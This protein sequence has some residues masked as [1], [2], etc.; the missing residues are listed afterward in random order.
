MVQ[1]LRV[2]SL[3][4]LLCAGLAI[5]QGQLGPAPG[6]QL[7][8]PAAKLDEIVAKLAALDLGEP[9]KAEFALGYLKQ[10]G[11]E[12]EGPALAAVGRFLKSETPR[13]R[14]AAARLVMDTPPAELVGDLKGAAA[15]L[16]PDEQS[17][18]AVNLS[19][20]H[21]DGEL[22]D[23][24]VARISDPEI[25]IDER[26]ALGS[27]L[28]PLAPKQL[29]L[30]YAE[31]LKSPEEPIRYVAWKRLTQLAGTE[32]G[33]TYQVWR[34]WAEEQIELS[35][36]LPKLPAEENA[37]FEPGDGGIGVHIREAGHS[38]KVWGVGPGSPAG[39]V[40]LEPG[41]L[42]DAV[43]GMPVAIR[44]MEEMVNFEFRGEPGTPVMITYRKPGQPIKTV[45]L[46]RA[47]LKVAMNQG[48]LV[49][50]GA[51]VEAPVVAFPDEVNEATIQAYI[52]EIL[53]GGSGGFALD[54]QRMLMLRRV[55]PA[56]VGLLLEAMET[57]DLRPSIANVIETIAD[58]SHREMIV[59]RLT[60]YPELIDCVHDHGWAPEARQQLL[61][62]LAKELEKDDPALPTDWINAI[63]QLQDPKS[64]PMLVDYFRRGRYP[65][66]TYDAI[67][68]IPGID[69][70]DAIA[71]MWENA[72]WRRELAGDTDVWFNSSYFSVR[73]AAQI[74]LEWGHVEALEVCIS[75]MGRR[76][77]TSR[78]TW[79]DLVR[80]H[81]DFVGTP[82]Q[83]EGWFLANRGKLIFVPATKKYVVAE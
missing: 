22:L 57:E 21:N 20:T 6:Q 15:D 29:V 43:N 30:A 28:L 47:E 27:Q 78:G 35:G 67:R 62:G 65:A 2:L 24:L 72:S 74:A 23:R 19:H 80:Q 61:D 79:D 70:R 38:L 45:E 77:W 83:T 40:G 44:S 31:L 11:A 58:E 51:F 16:D 7:L 68:G 60:D 17:T 75:R 54:G 46:K 56:Y 34:G 59:A 50:F 4:T 3:Q 1:I 39:E 82:E 37:N 64:F 42:I 52:D 69:L 5:G 8:K 10:M 73:D 53:T 25:E 14:A 48:G 32:M 9:D 36:D 63:V 66:V 81:I 33:K 12:L 76:E 49:R 13:V 41:D 18:L 26:R 71:K 55:G